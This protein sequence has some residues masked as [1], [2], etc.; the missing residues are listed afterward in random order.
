MKRTQIYLDEKLHSLLKEESRKTGKTVSE[1]IR[2]RLW[3]SFK[4]NQDKKEQLLKALDRA[5]G[6][7]EERDIDIESFVRELRKGNRVDSFG[8]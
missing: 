8:Y 4:E 2:Q 1:I 7:W 5:F 3:S 6:A